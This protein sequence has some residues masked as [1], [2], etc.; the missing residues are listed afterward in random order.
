M[1]L[2]KFLL[3]KLIM[4]MLYLG[5]GGHVRTPVVS[6]YYWLEGRVGR[7]EPPASCPGRPIL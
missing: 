7:L 3:S 2:V 5:N 6:I 4:S 1:R